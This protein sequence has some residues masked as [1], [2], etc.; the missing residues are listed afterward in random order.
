MRVHLCLVDP[1]MGVVSR[2]ED[3]LQSKPCYCS[4][5]DF[6]QFHPSCVCLENSDIP[7][8]FQILCVLFLPVSICWSGFRVS[9][10]KIGSRFCFSTSRRSCSIVCPSCMMYNDFMCLYGGLTQRIL[11]NAIIVESLIMLRTTSTLYSLRKPSIMLRTDLHRFGST[12]ATNSLRFLL[13]K[14]R[15]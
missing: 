4:L 7:V 1:L 6:A 2:W 12:V 13:W 8:P 15:T 14:S 3:F 10:T 11:V 9:K 5:P